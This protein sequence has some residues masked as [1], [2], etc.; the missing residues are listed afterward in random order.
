MASSSNGSDNPL[1]GLGITGNTGNEILTGLVED[2]ALGSSLSGAQASKYFTGPRAIIKVNGE[3]AGFAFQVSWKVNTMQNEVRTIDRWLPWEISPVMMQVE[4][5][6][7]MFH[8]PGKGPSKELLQSDVFS[9]LFF[10]YITIEIQDSKT[11]KVLFKT[12]KAV[13]T[14]RQQDVKA[15]SLSTIQLQWKAIGF[16]DEVEG[17]ELKFPTDYNKTAK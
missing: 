8:I 13:I 16:T 14:S 10:K 4:G 3:L 7:S 6:M 2:S 15:E 5:T 1:A 11:N 12:D 9:F 17:N